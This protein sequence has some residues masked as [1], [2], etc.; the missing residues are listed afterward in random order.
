MIRKITRILLKTTGI[1][2][3]AVI[4]LGIVLYFSIQSYTFQTWLG[5]ETSA[6]LSKELKADISIDR[7]SLDFFTKAN[8]KGVL[9]T[10]QHKDTLLK[11]DLL[12]DIKNFDYKKETLVLDKIVLKNLSARLIKYPK[13]STLNYQFLYNY[14]AGNGK[15]DTSTKKGWDVKLGK[16]YL[17]NMAF[18]YKNENADTKVSQNMNFN[19]LAFSKIYGEFSNFKNDDGDIFVDIYELQTREQSGFQLV[20]LSTQAKIGSKELLCNCLY[21]KTAKT[22]LKGE[23]AFNY[24]SWDDYSDF[25]NKIKINSELEHSYVNFGDVAAF[26]KE[27]NG[28][29]ET[30]YLSGGIKGYVSDL[31]LHNF[32]LEYGK[33]TK[34]HGNLTLSGLPDFS[35]SFLHF[36]AR[37]ITTNY[38]D[39]IQLP[40]YPFTEG[41]KLEIPAQIKAFGTISY[42][43]KFDGFMNDFTAYGAFHTALGKV[44]TDL[45][46]KLGKNADDI[47]Y[48]GKIST[49]NFNPGVLAGTSDL[50]NLSLKLLIKGRGLSLK[51]LNADVEGTIVNLNYKNYDYK[52]IQL[53]GNVKEKVF[54]GLL[55]SKDPNADFDFN[56]SI[57]FKNKIPEMDFISTVNKLNFKKLNITKEEAEISTQVL[58]TLKGDNINNLGGNINFDNTIYKNSQKEFKFSTFDLTLDQASADKK[59]VLNSNLVGLTVDGRFNIANLPAAFN[60]FL[61]SYYPAFFAKNKGKTIYSDALKFKLNIKKFNTISELLVKSLMVSPNTVLTGDFDASKNLF[62]INLKS[63]TVKFGSL[64]FNN[65]IIESYSQNNKINLVFKGTGIQLTDSIRLENYFM[66]LVSKD[67]DTKYNLEWDNKISP[68]TSGK[69]AGKISFLNHMATLNLDKF[70]ITSKDSTWNLKTT[71]P[72]VF[73]TSGSITVNPLLFTSRNQNI[74]LAGVLSEKPNDSLVVN[75]ASVILEQFNPLLQSIKLELDGILN[76]NVTVHNLKTFA[77]SSNLVFERLKINNN[78]LGQLVLKTNYNAAEKNIYVDGFTSLGLPDLSGNKSKNI[79][80]NGYYYLDKKEESLDIDFKATPANLKLLSPMLEGILTINNGLV[81]GGGKVHGTPDNIK[82]DGKLKL[83]NSEIKVDYTNV[84]YYI[85]GDLE[86]MPDQIRFTDLLLREKNQGLKAAPQGTINGNIFHNNFSKIQLDYDVTY[87]NMLV[88]NTTEKENNTF[89][90]KIYGSG[91]IGIWGFLSNVY[92]S[93][94]NKMNKNSKFYFPLDGPAEIEESD[95]IHFVKKDTLKNKKA[96][97]LT[98]FN[99]EMIIH[100]NP[101]LQAQIILDKRTGDILN[102]QGLGDLT[103]TLNTMG[104]F[105]MVG[106]YYITNGDYRFT[107]ENVINKKFDIQ[108]GSSIS[109][110]GDP[111]AAEINVTTSYKQRAS[112]APLLNDTSALYKGR[113]PVDCKLVITGKLFA[114]NINFAVDFP[115]LDANAKARIGNVLSDEVELNRQ[116]FSFLLFRS[117]VTPQIYNTNGGGVTAG[118]AAASTGSEMLSN[119]VSSFLNNYVGNLTGLSDLQLGLNYRPG[120]Q[121]NGEAIDLALSKQLFNNK[122]SIDGNFGVNGN[123]TNKNSS[124]IIDVNIEYKITDDGRYRLKGFNRSNDNTQIATTGGPYTQ[125][126]GLF[127]REEFESFNQLFK[128]YLQKLKKK[129]THK[130]AGS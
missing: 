15:K 85:T 128:R 130:A 18:S 28:L 75:T 20:N 7:V 78:S 114:P 29:N 23:I 79:S 82:I 92:M 86:L 56:G 123:Q 50:K 103:I 57:S 12:V 124:G 47:K 41:K 100:A 13:D 37:E 38:A 14:F 40:N 27:L 81:T 96:E 107:L 30:V 84:T 106:D 24:S 110:S 83:F 42:K 43:G 88:L 32:E 74:G 95:F 62:N 39:L 2:L 60:Q 125:G 117:F 54:N 45:S 51:T 35:T 6:Y 3:L 11:G 94:D 22:M 64:R 77:F 1:L 80:F 70:F 48:S 126:V 76:G 93:V 72:A 104:K 63:D 53:N 21:L 44:D 122:V 19:N 89:Y 68:N 99:L 52:S 113:F 116:V 101:N 66:Y 97:S 111:L 36:N 108:G 67:Q 87:N 61:S 102:F 46:V 71:N 10:D 59:I 33:Y 118:S 34:F 65:N 119:Q 58:I 120:S 25:L 16:I 91:K 73:D 127:Y 31:S 55:K 17:E 90:G 49:E 5:K 121:T 112:V 26:T 129:E 69:I 109:W 98:G 8:L 4:L 115:T 105:E 9:I